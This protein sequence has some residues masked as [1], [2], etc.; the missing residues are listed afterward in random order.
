[1][2][3]L[4]GKKSF[5]IG[6][7]IFLFSYIIINWNTVSWIFNYREI[8][9]L[10]YDFFN[11]YQNSNLLANAAGG[12]KYNSN[13]SLV[14]PSIG[15]VTNVVISKST[16]AKILENDLDYGAVYYPGSVAPGQNGQIVIL[17][18][19]APPGWPYIKH[20]WIFSDIEELVTGDTIVFNYNNKKYTYRV[21]EKKIIQK[22]QSVGQSELSKNNNILTLVSCWPPG[23]NYQRIA[24]TATL[25]I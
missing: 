6:G 8:N 24:V 5:A 3:Q 19:S 16:S 10:M 1:M 2:M 23:E 20:D 13:Y 14:I 4:K 25:V 9:G 15:L 7:I 12:T 18:H 11:P 21:L 22:G 17:G